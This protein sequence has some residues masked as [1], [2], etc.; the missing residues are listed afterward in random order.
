WATHRKSRTPSS[1]TRRFLSSWKEGPWT[2][3]TRLAH[4]PPSDL[5]SLKENTMKKFASILALAAL[6]LGAAFAQEPV[7]IGVLAPLSGAAAGTGQAQQAGF[8]VAL[9]EINDAGGVLG[10]P[11]EIIVEDTQANV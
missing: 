8:E 2:D 7:T 10:Q 1:S 11:L 9:K 6:G 4:P 5:H 3:Q